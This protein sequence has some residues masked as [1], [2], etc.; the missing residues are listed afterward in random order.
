MKTVL[1]ACLFFLYSSFTTA[2]QFTTKPV[3]IYGKGSCGDFIRAK[4]ES[5]DG[6]YIGWVTGFI[7][8]ANLSL[9]DGG[10]VLGAGD[11][12]IHDFMIL[13]ENYC[14]KNPMSS[15]LNGVA[16]PVKDIPAVDWQGKTYS[17]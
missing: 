6:F 12:D 3:M 14:R 4:A 11:P 17:E 8:G 2:D 1:I 10:N 13:V 7:N 16:V 5:Q 15:F 9:K